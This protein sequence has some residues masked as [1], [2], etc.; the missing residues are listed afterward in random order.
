LLVGIE[1]LALVHVGHHRSWKELVSTGLALAESSS[2]TGDPMSGHAP[3]DSPLSSVRKVTD[4]VEDRILRQ[5]CPLWT[6][7]R[8]PFYALL[9]QRDGSILNGRPCPC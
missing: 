5:C 8:E 9:G 4:R 1:E 7:H 3:V 6:S 2:T